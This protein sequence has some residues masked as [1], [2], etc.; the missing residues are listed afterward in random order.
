MFSITGLGAVF[1][2]ILATT[3]TR[4]CVFVLECSQSQGWVQFF[5]PSTVGVFSVYSTP[6]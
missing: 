3:N 4:V 6:S 5:T 2:N 1:K